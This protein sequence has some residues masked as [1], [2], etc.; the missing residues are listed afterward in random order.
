MNT[1]KNLDKANFGKKLTLFYSPATVFLV[2]KSQRK[3]VA[4]RAD[5]GYAPATPFLKTECRKQKT[6]FVKICFFVNLTFFALARRRI[7]RFA[8]S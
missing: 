1:C 4:G 3:T 2:D 5:G 7:L 6:E 8:T